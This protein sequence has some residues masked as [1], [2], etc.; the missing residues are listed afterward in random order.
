MIDPTPSAKIARAKILNLLIYGTIPGAPKDNDP[1][2]TAPY[3][4]G[5]RTVDELVRG[6]GMKS[7]GGVVTAGSPAYLYVEARC[8]ELAQLGKVARIGGLVTWER[9]DRESRRT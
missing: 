1:E 3:P 2:T 8:A 4:H 6:L 9:Y 5:G 7:G